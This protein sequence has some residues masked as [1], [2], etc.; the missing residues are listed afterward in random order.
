MRDTKRES[1]DSV[2]RSSAHTR[3]HRVGSVNSERSV[4]HMG[5]GT[6]ERRVD[7]NGT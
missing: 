3:E 2:L 5:R 1:V 4:M 7:M 6:T